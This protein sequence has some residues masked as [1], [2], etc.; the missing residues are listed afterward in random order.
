MTVIA[1]IVLNGAV[2][3]FWHFPLIHRHVEVHFSTSDEFMR[4]RAWVMASGAISMTSWSSAIVLGMLKNVPWSYA[5]IMSVYL[6]VVCFAMLT[7]IALRN[8]ILKKG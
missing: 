4:K 5:Q 1:V 2:F 6:G 7:A 8:V 3:H